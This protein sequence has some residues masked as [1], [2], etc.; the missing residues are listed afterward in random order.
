MSTSKMCKRFY[1]TH[2]GIMDRITGEI[3]PDE[4]WFVFRASDMCVD[5]MLEAYI[6]KCKWIGGSKDH[7]YAIEQLL[8]RV[9][10]YQEKNPDK[11][12]VD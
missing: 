8:E 7:I 1:T 12:F 9:K 5:H 10:D 11:L 3:L 4:E 2:L 6:K